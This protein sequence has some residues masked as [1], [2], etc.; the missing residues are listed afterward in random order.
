MTLANTH[1]A[2]TNIINGVKGWNIRHIYNYYGSSDY[3]TF[4][5]ADGGN[6]DIN[7]FSAI[8]SSTPNEYKGDYVFPARYFLSGKNLRVKG[9][10]YIS[11]GA[12]TDAWLK[13]NAGINNTEKTYETI[14]SIDATTKYHFFGNGFTRSAYTEFELI[15]S[16]I[17]TLQKPPKLLMG[18][19]GYFRYDEL[20]SDT[21]LLNN[22]N[23]LIPIVRINPLVEINSDLD[24]A[25]EPITINLNFAGSYHIDTINVLNLS[26]E[27]LE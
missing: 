12:N 23:F 10:L 27:E 14:G 2:P 9:M 4:N 1:I 26:I 24:T 19:S 11:S 16:G 6:Y 5:Y 22:R 18:A 3:T 13:I 15:Y 21:N 17:E 8:Q 20:S 7:L 25:P